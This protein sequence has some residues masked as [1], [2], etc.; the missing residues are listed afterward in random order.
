ML[1]YGLTLAV[2]AQIQLQAEEFVSAF[3]V[4]GFNNSCNTQ[5]NF[6]EVLEC[7][8]WLE[9]ILCCGG[10]GRFIVCFACIFHGGNL[11]WFNPSDQGFE[12][13]DT[14][15]GQQGIDIPPE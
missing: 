12:F 3:D 4:R 14:M 6:C 9:V 10:N 1:K 15:V 5:I 11:F 13:V 7:N 8:L 2:R